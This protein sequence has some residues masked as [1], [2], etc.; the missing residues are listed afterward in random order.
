M[1]ES[2]PVSRRSFLDYLLGGGLV[3]WTIG[4]AAPVISYLWPAQRQGPGAQA[5]SAGKA[6][7]WEEWQAKMVAVSGQPALVLRTA[8]GFRAFSAVCTHLGCIVQWNGQRRQI[9][10]PCHAGFFDPNGRVVSGPPPRPLTEL[11]VAL[12]NGEVM[13]KSL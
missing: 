6:E 13:V 9:A 12:V 5:V 8:Q 11:G 7:G 4:G 2:D 1:K 3:V 10:C